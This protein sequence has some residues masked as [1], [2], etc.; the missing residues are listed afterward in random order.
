VANAGPSDAANVTLADTIPA[1]TTFLNLQ[2]P[3]AWSCSTPGVGGTGTINC[4]IATFPVSGSAVFTLLVQ[5]NA[6]PTNGTITNT[7][8]V[9]TTTTDPVGANNSATTTTTI[10]PITNFTATK[11]VAGTFVSGTTVTYTV[12]LTNNMGHTQ[13]NNFGNEFADILPAGLALTGATASTGTILTILPSNIVTWNGSIPT[14]TSVTITITATITAPS[15]TISNQGNAIIDTDNDGTN[16]SA[17]FTD[18]PS[19]AAPS[20]PTTFTVVPAPSPA[21]V[22]GTKTASGTFAPGS[23]VTYTIVLSNSGPSAQ[24]NNPGDEFVDVLPAQLTLVNATATSGTALA[25]VGTNTV[26]WNGSIPAA[27]SVTIT[28]HAIVE[29]NVPVGTT[30]TNQG[31]IH[32]DADGDGTNESTA[33]TDDPSQPGSGNG[34]GFVVAP[35]AAASDIPALDPRSL[36]VLATLLAAIG[37]LI[38]RRS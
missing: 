30:I 27:G 31:T 24:L 7:A 8:T 12:I 33:V 29:T 38:T 4:S 23:T 34:T 22:T 6:S 32:Y 16:E 14:G 28:I 17:V 19:T 9:T 11:S 35:A 25:T 2:S 15:G 18:D 5:V 37:V 1:G 21:T 20:D 3:G 13:G 36:I 26:T 10:A